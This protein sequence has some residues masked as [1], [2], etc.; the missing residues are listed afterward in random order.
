MENSDG[1]WATDGSGTQYWQP[2]ITAPL[3]VPA[4]PPSVTYQGATPLSSPANA[5]TTPVQALSHLIPGGSHGATRTPQPRALPPKIAVNE[6]AYVLSARI[7]LDMAIPAWSF[8]GGVTGRI[9]SPANV[10]YAN[11]GPIDE[12]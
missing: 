1:Y 12:Y 4:A 2:L 8:S 3:H 10:Y 9:S 7:V 6:P 5:Y 11:I